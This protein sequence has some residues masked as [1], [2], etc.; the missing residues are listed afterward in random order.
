MTGEIKLSFNRDYQI[1][2]NKKDFKFPQISLNLISQESLK[3]KKET[4]HILKQKKVIKIFNLQLE[5]LKKG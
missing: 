1:L 3:I 5:N 2:Q 4:P